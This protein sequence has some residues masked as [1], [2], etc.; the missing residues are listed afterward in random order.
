MNRIMGKI[1][2]RI[3]NKRNINNK[4][5][6]NSFAPFIAAFAIICTAAAP[7][8][9]MGFTM[10]AE[11]AGSFTVTDKNAVLYT[12]K[13]VNVYKTPDVSGQVVTTIAKNLP[14]Q[15]TGITSNGWFRISLDGVFYVTGD[16]LEQRT[17]T[18]TA[19]SASNYDVNALTKGTFSF[20]NNNE[21]RKMD[22]D[23]IEDM[24][25][26]TYIKYL[27]SFLTGNA[28][29]DYCIIRED[30]YTLKTVYDKAAKKDSAT[31]AMSMQQ[32]LI[33][34]R[35]NVLSDSISGPFRSEKDLKL[36]LNRSI[37]Y[38]ID[39]FSSIYKSASVGSDEEKMKKIMQNVIDLMKAEQGVSFKYKME[40]GSYKTSDGNESK[41]WIIEFERA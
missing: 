16:S 33:Q 15:V 40:Y 11:A 23:D 13:T 18:G 41:G 6:K 29:I 26:N 31:A 32:Y 17:Q 9:N 25:D 35:N 37:R 20:F 10:V 3:Y 24:D 38:D 22:E 19:A 39:K 14:V 30:G 1:K 8:L 5:N 4:N 12:T 7:P 27:D 36:A 21:L 28:M 34:Y 2:E